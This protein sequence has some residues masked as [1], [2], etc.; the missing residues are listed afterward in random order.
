VAAR[1][2]IGEPSRW[3]RPDLHLPYS[4]PGGPWMYSGSVSSAL[5]HLPRSHGEGASSDLGR[6]SPHIAEWQRLIAADVLLPRTPRPV[7]NGRSR[8]I[9]IRAPCARSWYP[10]SMSSAPGKRLPAPSL[11]SNSPTRSSKFATDRDAAGVQDVAQQRPGV[12]ARGGVRQH[13]HLASS[14]A[15]R[16]V[17]PD[18][19]GDGPA[20]PSPPQLRSDRP[21]HPRSTSMS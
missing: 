4:R 21:S 20:G 14:D 11:S 1:I 3:P 13:G 12:L 2:A 5:S 19:V 16:S 8:R 15:L 9:G 7:L 10:K 18:L 6:I 17:F